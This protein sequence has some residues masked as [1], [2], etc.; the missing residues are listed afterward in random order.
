MN[1]SNECWQATLV[2]GPLC[3]GTTFSLPDTNPWV[4][5]VG[6]FSWTNR[7]LLCTRDYGRWNGVYGFSGWYLL[8]SV[9]QSAPSWGHSIPNW[10]P[11]TVLSIYRSTCF[12]LR[13][14]TDFSR[15]GT[16]L[17]K[18]YSVLPPKN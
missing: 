8:W 18:K 1:P 16:Y 2:T 15:K 7:C 5:T 12:A 6:E 13:V 4:N 9:W 11:A 17:G 10:R 14:L 3:A